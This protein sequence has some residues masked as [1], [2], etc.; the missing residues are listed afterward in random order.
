MLRLPFQS[1]GLHVQY[2]SNRDGDFDNVFYYST[3]TD[4]WP[5]LDWTESEPGTLSMVSSLQTFFHHVIS[6]QT[7]LAS[8]DRVNLEHNPNYSL[9]PHY[10][11]RVWNPSA[12]SSPRCTD[13]GT[14]EPALTVSSH[15]SHWSPLWL[16]RKQKSEI[17]HRWPKR[18]PPFLKKTNNKKIKTPCISVE[19]RLDFNLNVFTYVSFQH[20]QWLA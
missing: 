5:P 7:D 12:R 14:R 15:L 10:C 4:T 6:T 1:C 2:T 18:V 11:T 8:I 9:L 13:C 3:R 19:L 16:H 17:T 20:S